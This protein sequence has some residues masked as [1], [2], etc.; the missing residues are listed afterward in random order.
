[1][2]NQETSSSWGLSITGILVHKNTKL[3][4]SVDR[5]LTQIIEWYNI[6]DTTSGNYWTIEIDTWHQILWSNSYS[7]YST[8][9]T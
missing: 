5:K 9:W 8:N 4:T 7:W 1:M 6:L 2:W 3:A